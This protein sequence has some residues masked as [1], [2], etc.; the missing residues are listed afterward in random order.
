MYANFVK[1]RKLINW[2]RKGNFKHKTASVRVRYSQ[3]NVWSTNVGNYTKFK[4]KLYP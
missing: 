1:F 3:R 4:V 2:E